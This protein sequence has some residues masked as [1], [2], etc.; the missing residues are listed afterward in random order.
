[1]KNEE[2][3][4][5]IE[6]ECDT[7][8]I[9]VGR[10][11]DCKNC[12]GCPGNNSLILTVKNPIGAK[13]GQKICFETKQNKILSSVYVVYIQPLILTSI[14]VI[15]GYLIANYIHKSI[16]ICEVILGGLFFIISLIYIRFAELKIK[17]DKESIPVITK[18]IS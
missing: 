12:G 13:V 9:K 18:I 6:V 17:R 3:G 15:L 11:S 1:M 5:V 10:H 16:Q 7:A 14:G 8:K 4:Y 2:V